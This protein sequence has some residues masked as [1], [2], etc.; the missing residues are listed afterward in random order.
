[1]NQAENNKNKIQSKKSEKD[2]K[3][4]LKQSTINLNIETDLKNK[5]YEKSTK[6]SHTNNNLI[7]DV[8]NDDEIEEDLILRL[9]PIYSDDAKFFNI[10]FKVLE[11]ILYK[12]TKA[13]L[14]IYKQNMNQ[15]Q[16]ITN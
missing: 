9:N 16:P 15:Y 7:D 2:I 4:L 6:K 13:F 14:T 5:L 8:Q 1:M 11:E 10:G 3:S 12:D